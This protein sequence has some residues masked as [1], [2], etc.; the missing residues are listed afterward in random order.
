MAERLSDHGKSSTRALAQQLL[1]RWEP[2]PA[3]AAPAAQ[4]K[5]DPASEGAPWASLLT[6]FLRAARHLI[7]TRTQSWSI[8]DSQ[9]IYDMSQSRSRLTESASA[10]V[11]SL[12]E[13]P[14]WWVRPCILSGSVPLMIRRWLSRSKFPV[15]LVAGVSRATSASAAPSVGGSAAPVSEDDETELMDEQLLMMLDRQREVRCWLW[16]PSGCNMRTFRMFTLFMQI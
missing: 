16:C 14:P 12:Q 10:A 15:C 6:H 3:Q 1:G 7:W 11:C 13:D 9:T 2:K 5:A 8:R 4:P